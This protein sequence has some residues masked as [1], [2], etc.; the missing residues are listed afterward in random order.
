MRRAQGQTEIARR[1]LEASDK[2]LHANRE[3]LAWWEAGRPALDNAETEADLLQWE[4]DLREAS[5]RTLERLASKRVELRVAAAVKAVV[6]TESSLCKICFDRPSTCALLPC[7]HH[8]F[9]ES[10][11]RQIC[12]R[13]GD[14]R[15]VCPLC[16]TKVEGIFPTYSG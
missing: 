16:R 10:C 9:C 13:R 11:A 4:K 6:G 8:A 3:R 14:R 15:P 2:E 1:T 7:R 12:S 5:V